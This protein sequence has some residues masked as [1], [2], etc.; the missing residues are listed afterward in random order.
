M[1]HFRI[2]YLREYKLRIILL[3]LYFIPY[4]YPRMNFTKF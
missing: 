2:L 1:I 3:I 4:F